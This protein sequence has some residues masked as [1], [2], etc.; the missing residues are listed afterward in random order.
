MQYRHLG[1]Y[2][3]SRLGLGTVQFGLDYGFT[4]KLTEKD[5]EE[6][7]TVC[8]E[9]GVNF[10]DTARD[11]GDSENKIGRYLKHHPSSHFVVATKI[12]VIPRLVCYDKKLLETHIR[13]SI[14]A[15]RKALQRDQLQIL[16]LHNT[17]DYVMRN[18]RFWDLMLHLRDEKLFEQFGI[19]FYE[20]EVATAC[21]QQHGE[22]IDVIQAPFNIVDKRFSS[23]GN[24]SRRKRPFFV[25][26]STFLKGLIMANEQDIQPE[27]SGVKPLTQKLALLSERSGL[28]KSE[29]V[30]LSV[31]NMRFIDVILVGVKSPAELLDN[32]RALSKL[33]RFKEYAPKISRLKTSNVFIIDPGKWELEKNKPS[34]IFREHISRLIPKARLRASAPTNVLTII[35][36]R[37]GSTRLPGK[38]MRSIL[39]KPMLLRQI[40]RICHSK[41]I[42]RI[43]VATTID[44]SDDPIEKLCIQNN[45]QC[46]RGSINDVLDRYYQAAHKFHADNVVR[47]TGDCPLIDSDIMDQV[48]DFYF[49]NHCDYASCNRISNTFPDGLDVEIFSTEMLDRVHH[50]AKLPS[51]REHVTPYFYK[52]PNKFTLGDFRSKIDLSG[53]RWTVDEAEDFK[54]VVKIYEALYPNNPNFKTQDIL[55]LLCQRPELEK[56]NSK[57]QRNE[58]YLRS[59]EKDKLFKKTAGS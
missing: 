20:P 15:S 48:I 18:T 45:L 51:E 30:L 5:V 19:S 39:G 13:K 1:K 36:A 38:V 4:K 14:D 7:L 22:I 31:Y 2:K 40:D 59:L 37:M 57:Y 50:E 6:I 21:L 9:Q 24:I 29:L 28:T 27:L 32:I 25:S 54:F 56:I 10:L 46:F 55:D 35:Q 41:K 53:Y 47:I 11:Y 12:Q 3:I 23:I 42:N 34:K 43:I 49:A 33:R 44:P 16:Q 8:C 58:G 52:H 17:P 26:R